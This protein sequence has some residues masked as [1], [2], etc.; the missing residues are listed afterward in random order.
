MSIKVDKAAYVIVLLGLLFKCISRKKTLKSL[1]SG[2][3]G[4][5]LMFSGFN[6][7]DLSVSCIK[8]SVTLHE[9]FQR[10][11]Q[12]CLVGIVI[13]VVSTMLV[14]SSSATVAI[15][16]ALFNSNLIT[17]EAALGLMFGDNIGTCIT[18][19]MASLK[20]GVYGKRTAWAHTMYNIIGVLIALV[21]FVPFVK[22]VQGITYYIGGDK[23]KLVAN[24]HTIFNIFSAILFLPITKYYVKF[25]EW[26]VPDKN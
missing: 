6:I 8:E 14:H 22:M 19:Q 20:M 3:I 15:T 7:L 17:F 24:A 16:I 11:G 25:I 4:L 2:L 26:L 10:Y 1:G 12:N 13:G 9:I 18:A 21:F 23:S 5:G